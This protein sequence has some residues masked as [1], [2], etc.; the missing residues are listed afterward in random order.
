MN[1]TEDREEPI[2][3]SLPRRE[4]DP[5]SMPRC[6]RCNLLYTVNKSTSALKLTYCSFLCELGDLGFSMQGLE[7]MERAAKAAPVT[8]GEPAPDQ[9][10]ELTG[11]A[12]II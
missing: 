9:E 8:E 6:K 3:V 11:T 1:S 5:V 7:Q 12:A 2:Q 10:P 4:G